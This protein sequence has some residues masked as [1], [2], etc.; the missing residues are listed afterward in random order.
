MER[1]IVYGRRCPF[2]EAEWLAII[3]RKSSRLSNM[4]P[5]IGKKQPRVRMVT[6]RIERIHSLLIL[7]LPQLNSAH[8]QEAMSFFSKSATL[9]LGEYE[10]PCVVD[11]RLEALPIVSVLCRPRVFQASWRESRY[12][13]LQTEGLITYSD[14]RE[15]RAQDNSANPVIVLHDRQSHAA[16]NALARLCIVRQV[17]R[18]VKKLTKFRVA[19][20][21]EA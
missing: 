3:R 21:D 11:D 4:R 18:V 20:F 14:I 17:K 6:K 13:N 5:A 8:K 16:S 15:C 19:N 9:K 7:C 12:V 2:P 1:G 10:G